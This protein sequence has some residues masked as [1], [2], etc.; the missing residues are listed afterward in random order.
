MTPEAS[1][2]TL[3]FIATAIFLLTLLF[4][5]PLFVTIRDRFRAATPEIRSPYDWEKER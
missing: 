5:P 4:G 1:F 2:T 3:E